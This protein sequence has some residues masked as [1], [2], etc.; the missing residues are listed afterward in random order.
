MR[1][2][3]MNN[4]CVRESAHMKRHREELRKGGRGKWKG[5]GE[6]KGEKARGYVRLCRGERG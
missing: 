1:A 5:I 6:R 3:N 4:M 2:V